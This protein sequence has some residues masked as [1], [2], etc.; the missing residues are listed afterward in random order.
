[1]LSIREALRVMVGWSVPT[2]MHK[3]SRTALQNS[4]D[5]S[6]CS[7]GQKH[8]RCQDGISSDWFQPYRVQ[9]RKF[10][11]GTDSGISVEEHGERARGPRNLILAVDR[12]KVARFSLSIS[13]S[14]SKSCPG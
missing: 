13:F 4:M 2:R 8:V 7:A 10:S 5:L 11:L 14:C 12:S 9:S 1:M 6:H 3:L